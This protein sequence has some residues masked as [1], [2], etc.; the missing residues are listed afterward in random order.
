MSKVANMLNM[1]KI[2][3]DGKIHTIQD[4]AD[5]LEVSTRM[6]RIYKQE[7]EQAG[8]YIQGKQ[9]INGGY[10]LDNMKSTIDIGL[11]GEEIYQLKNMKKNEL[12]EAII[13]KIIKAYITN[14]HRKDNT[15]S[16]QLMP[17]FT[18]IYKD[19]RLAINNRNKIFIE[20][21]SVNSGK[22]KRIIHPAELF[23]YLNNWYVA[24]FCEL[25]N[26]IRLFK[27]ND[28]ISYKI[29]DKKYE[30]VNLK[31]WSKN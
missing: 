5:E 23:T 26:E 17:E 16:K 3:E 8:I 11:T 9:G 22:T 13:N 31:I 12:D 27:L 30:E 7:L 2:L 14:E 24:A 6:I 20:F 1:V 28:I 18:E 29:L 10:I 19:F 25:R 21:K 15:K 4:L